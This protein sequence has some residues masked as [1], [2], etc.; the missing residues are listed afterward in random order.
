MFID[1]NR[2]S[3]WNRLLR[4]TAYV[5][6]FCDAVRQ[7]ANSNHELESTELA[8]AENLLFRLAQKEFYSEEIH[9]LKLNKTLSKSSSL[10]KTTPKLDEAQILRVEGRIEK[11]I[12]SEDTKFPIILPKGSRITQLLIM[13]FHKNY[14][15]LNHETVINEMRQRFYIPRLRAVLKNILK[16]CQMC[17]IKKAVPNCPQMAK[18]PEARLAAFCRP[19]TYTGVDYFGPIMVT[20]GRHT[21]KRYGALFTCLTVRAVHIEVVNSLNISS[22]IIAIRNFMCRRGTPREFF[23]D[24][25]TNFVSAEK[26]IREA[27]KEVDTN[28]LIRVFTTATT[29]WT[30]IPPSSPHMGGAWERLV[31]SVKNVFYNISHTRTPND[32]LLRGMLAEVE[33]IINSRPLVY[34]PIEH[35]NAEAIT[36][37]HLLVY[38][39]NGMKPLATY[40]DSG[41]ALKHNWLTSQQ[42]ADTFWRK[43]VKEYLPSLTLRTKWHEKTKPLQV[44]DLVIVVDPSSPR[45]VWPRGKIMETTVASDGQV[46]KAKILT[47]TGIIVRPAARLA[48][49]DVSSI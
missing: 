14:K 28:E 1:I 11:A 39:S 5:L 24:N 19:F 9:I 3:N 22:C 37:N 42:Y 2:F 47:T 43:W 12:V 33:N 13:H 35:E 15:H 20:V 38:S 36:P 45:N 23:S 32:E 18:L 17:K 29:K 31:R 10:Y 26:E 48:V 4:T 6:R 40:D 34:V 25:G 46:R 16:Q 49:L 7:K 30:F 8:R 41:I 27:V 44:G 21:E